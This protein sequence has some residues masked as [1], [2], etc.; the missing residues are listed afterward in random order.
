M[1]LIDGKILLIITSIFLYTSVAY[2]NETHA[3]IGSELLKWVNQYPSQKVNGEKTALLDM[4]VIKKTLKEILP[5]TELRTLKTYDVESLVDKIDNFIVVNKCM[6]HDCPSELA[7]VVI[8]LERQRLWVGFFLRE[9]SRTSTR[10]YSNG[11]DY[12]ILPDTIKQAFLKR[13]GD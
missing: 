13:H 2:A 3:W 11:D 6:P 10:W 8:D 5:K 7:M 4:P 12:S 9:E 1:R